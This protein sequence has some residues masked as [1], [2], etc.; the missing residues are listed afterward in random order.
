[1]GFKIA[2]NFVRLGL[3]IIMALLFMPSKV[4][5]AASEGPIV[6]TNY[7]TIQG[8]TKNNTEQWKGVPYGGPVSGAK[9][10]KKP[11]AP[12]PWSGIKQTTVSKKAIQNNGGTVNGQEDDALTLDI[13]R[14][15]NERKNLPVMVYIHG[16]NNQTGSS[17]EI[18]GASFAAKHNV[19]FVSINHR[20][21]ALGYNP[22]PAL[23][24]GDSENDSGNY[25]LLDIHQALTWVQQN[26][27]NFG[28]NGHNITLSG[29]S[30]GG[31]NVM[32]TLISPLFRGQF[33][34]AI[35][36]SGGMTTSKVA[37]SQKRF[38]EIFAPLV[39]ADGVKKDTDSAKKWLLTSD[40]AVKKYF[41][42][43]SADRIEKAIGDAAIR[44]D[45]FPH[46]YRDG[47]VLPKNGY[48]T[49]R[50]NNVPVILFTG[51]HEFASF[52]S[53]D[54][55]F[56]SSFNDGSIYTDQTKQEQF[57]FVKKYGSQL[58]SSFN[59][60]DSANKMLAHGY[61][62]P[63]YGL[64]MSFGDDSS[65][66]GKEMGML[67]AYHGVFTGLLDR[68]Q[69]PY[70]GAYKTVGATQLADVF[71]DYLANFINGVPFNAPNQQRLWRAYNISGQTL[72]LTADK[73]KAYSWMAR[74]NY[75]TQSVLRDIRSDRSLAPAT[76]D[77]LLKHVMN[78]R[79]F[80]YPLDRAY[81]NETWFEK[82]N[83]GGW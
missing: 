70:N 43:L 9:R 17:D 49:H 18:S 48:D 55:Y 21:G 71:Q 47:Y 41:Y 81:H 13:W 82:Q 74:K 14:P 53:W 32:A 16:G 36:F 28:G 20:L 50:Y 35:V 80:S 73:T 33:Q 51:T 62:A 42:Q 68:F 6:H 56:S 8:L 66:V 75:T 24:D 83:N 22:L 26:I 11:T 34:R 4:N 31:R 76:K 46:L 29:F 3:V 69:D 39:V 40:P 25:G 2:R 78:N 38:A 45:G 61:R 60:E 44:M 7:G 58:Y 79:W 77:Y 65:V 15:A 64:R 63:I 12:T 5:A 23:K 10:W 1:M 19:I 59:V 30:S 72:R 54:P 27:G 67:G 52:A 37:P 57:N